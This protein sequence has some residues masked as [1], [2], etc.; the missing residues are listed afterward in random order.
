MPHHRLAQHPARQTPSCDKDDD[1]LGMG[2]SPEDA[3][4]MILQNFGI[5]RQL[6]TAP[7]PRKT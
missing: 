5:H 6:Y 2:S 1:L 3:D 4:N 7:K